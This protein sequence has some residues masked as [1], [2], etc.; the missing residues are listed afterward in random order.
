MRLRAAAVLSV[1]AGLAPGAAAAAPLITGTAAYTLSLTEAPAFAGIA[2]LQGD[3]AASIRGIACDT[4]ENVVD[5]KFTIRPTFGASAFNTVESRWT[6]S[7]TTMT[8]KLSAETDGAVTERSAGTA[9][10]TPAGLS[11][12]LTE[13]EARTFDLPGS[14]VFPMEMVS[15]TIDAAVDGRRLVRFT[16]YDGSGNGEAFYKVSV[17]IGNPS[18]EPATGVDR[19]LTV[20]LGMEGMRHWP[21]TFSYFPP[22]SP[23]DAD[24]Q[25][26]TVA[27]VFENGYVLDTT[28]DFVFFV[29]GLTLNSF[30]PLDP[31]PAC[32]AGGN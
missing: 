28:Y 26:S 7:P 29:A 8:F 21:M 1:L 30:E 9:T 18:T 22:D 5:M 2:D 24:P 31:V 12:A 4:Y 23:G 32:P 6:E 27:V 20:T 15:K 25:Y 19:D 3:L 16:V 11:V 10:K 13:P 17:L 14:F